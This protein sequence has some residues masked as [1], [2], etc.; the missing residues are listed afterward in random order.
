MRTKELDRSF[1]A[2]F[3]GELLVQV[4]QYRSLEKGHTCPQVGP[5]GLARLAP[6]RI[7][8]RQKI[9]GAIAVK[10]IRGHNPGKC[11]ETCGGVP[12]RLPMWGRD[13]GLSSRRGPRHEANGPRVAAR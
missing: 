2:P 7:Y 5:G 4:L 12:A 9:L 1:P 11:G 6:G 8:G 10:E 3:H 13:D